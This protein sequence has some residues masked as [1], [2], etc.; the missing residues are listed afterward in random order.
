[1]GVEQRRIG[2]GALQEAAQL[3]EVV[4]LAA[5]HR[6]GGEPD[7]LV[8]ILDHAAQ[9]LVRLILPG[10]VLGDA[11]HRPIEPVDP[12]PQ[13]GADLLADLAQV[14]ARG[15]DARGDRFLVAAIE[16]ELMDQGDDVAGAAVD[17][18]RLQA[19]EDA[20]PVAARRLRRAV[21]RQVGVHVDQARGVLGP[22][23]IAP[24]Q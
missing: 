19:V 2:E 8:A 13:V 11:P 9:E 4:A 14:L 24:V 15:V 21:E 22:L 18:R 5:I 7:E 16:R 17:H 1:M 10:G 6:R 20:M 23:Q 12:L 3:E